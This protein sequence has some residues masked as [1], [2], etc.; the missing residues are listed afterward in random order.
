MSP[1]QSV[2]SDWLVARIKRSAKVEGREIEFLNFKTP[3][4]MGQ[5]EYDDGVALG[6]VGEDGEPTS[7]FKE[8]YSSAVTK[9]GITVVGA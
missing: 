9:F 3:L 8:E 5:H 1:F 2:V 7:K 4:Y 6:Y